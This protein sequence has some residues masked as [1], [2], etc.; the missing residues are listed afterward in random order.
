[1][2]P[3]YSQNVKHLIAVDCIIFG[4]D[5]EGLRLLLIKRAVEPGAGAWS[6]MGGFL[7][8]EESL[9][10]AAKR[11]LYELTELSE[12]YLEQLNTYGEVNRDPG[13]RVISVAYY[14]LIRTDKYD[15]ELIKKYGAKWFKIED[16][17]RLIFD[18]NDMVDVA[19]RR[20]Q[21]RTKTRP[22]GFELLPEKFSIPQLQRLYEAINQ[23]NIDK[24]NFRRKI[25]G[26]QLL[27]KLNE[28][29]KG[30]S[31]RGAFLYKFDKEKYYKFFN[32]GYHFEIY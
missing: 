21:R 6:L 23:E 1:M 11:V 28:K 5:R 18:H 19:L 10:K 27:V 24:R 7:K 14:A 29:E 20:L 25:L 17:P 32:N 9:D 15:E 8:E 12:V 2:L 22:I 4:F 26:T 16:L 30:V 31:K 13:G 3:Y